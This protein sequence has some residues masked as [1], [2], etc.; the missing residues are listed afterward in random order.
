MDQIACDILL[1]KAIATNIRGFIASI[2]A[3]HE[4][5]GIALRARQL[6][7][8]IAPMISNRRM[9]VWPALDTRPSRSLPPEEC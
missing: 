3:S 8:D 6:S 1:A 5:T 4:P 7:R 9:S 2:R